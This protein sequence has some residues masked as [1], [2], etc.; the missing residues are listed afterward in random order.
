M[1]VYSA[2]QNAFSQDDL[3][4]VLAITS[5]ISIAIENSLSFQAVS[6][7]ATKDPLTGLANASSLFLE[8]QS[9]VER[10]NLECTQITV[11]VADLDRFKLVNDRYGHMAGNEVLKLISEGFRSS[12]RKD[13]FVARMGGDE[14]VFVLSNSNGLGQEQRRKQLEE[15]VRDCGIKVC[16]TN[17]LGLSIGAAI[18]PRDGSNPEELLA[19]ADHDMY[20][21]KRSRRNEESTSVGLTNLVGAVAAQETVTLESAQEVE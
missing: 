12:C 2:E 10:C 6:M 7:Q 15:I 21:N 13:D 20:K 18:Y 19:A 17:I 14:F 16:G 5:K 9:E 8:L 4:L 3:R 11:L 1:A